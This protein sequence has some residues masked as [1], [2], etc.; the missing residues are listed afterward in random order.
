[1][2]DRILSN[3][4]TTLLYT[5]GDSILD[6]GSYNAHGITPGEL[7][8][9]NDDR[10][11]PEFRGRDLS[12]RGRFRLEHRAIDGSRVMDLH[13]QVRG[14]S[15]H[16]PSIVLVTIG[17]NDLLGGLAVDRGP[18]IDAFGL[19]LERFAREIAIRPLLLGNVYDPTLGDDSRNFLGIDPALA[20]SN[21]RR[22]NEAI[23]RV[24]SQH[25]RLVD[26]HAHFLTG[27]L[28]W[29]TMTIEPS[30]RGASEIRRCFLDAIENL[31][32]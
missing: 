18:G 8:I 26:L 28:S 17:G 20:R 30:L 24:A 25:G 2:P 16:G 21:L 3:G 5:F 13:D 32:L 12:S 4:E 23:A 27:D 1:M 29:F 15:V 11:F 6:C 10:L 22:V 14:L 9:K 19:A 31:G 7:L